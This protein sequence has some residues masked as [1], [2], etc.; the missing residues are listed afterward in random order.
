MPMKHDFDYIVIGSGFGGSV[1]ALRLAEKGYRVC[2]IERGKRYRP[3][4]FATSNWQL[5]KWLWMPKLFLRGIQCLTLLKNSLVLTGS[6]VGGGSLGYCAVLLEPPDPFFQDPQWAGLEKDWRTVLAPFYQTARKMLG[7]TQNP[8]LWK[9]DDLIREYARDIGRE[10]S[11]KPTEVGIY[12]GDDQSENPDPFFG[13]RGPSRKGCD[14]SGACMV[15]CRQGGKNSLDKN[16]LYL[17]EKLGATILPETEVVAIEPDPQGGYAVTTRSSTALFNKRKK[18][19][20]SKGVVVSAGALGTNR[21][22]LKCKRDNQLPALS[23]RLGKKVRTNSEV[24]LGITSRDRKADFSKGISITSSLFIDEVTHIEPVRYPAGSD[25]MFWLSALLTDGG[26]RIPRPLRYLLTCIRH[27]LEFLR[28]AIPFGWAKRS[29]IL[30]VMQTL[31]NQMELF[32]KRKWYFPFKATLGSR[33]PTSTVP[34]YIPQ[35]NEAARAIAKKINGV[36]KSAITE[37]LFNAPITAHIIGGCVIGKD[38]ESGVVDKYCRAFSYQNFYIID[39][40]VIPANLGVN[41]SL[42]ITAVAEY[43]M[44]HVPAK[45]ET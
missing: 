9:S 4:D 24:L 37:V 43:A 38:S 42:T 45:K 40:S 12:F 5:W 28:N 31:D 21:L 30:L 1:S 6:G 18:K 19:L 27:P 16:Y 3:R 35:A 2:V 22:L 41:P 44:S 36:P 13:G 34:S 23:A 33:R 11:F 7:V 29:I 20:Y 39:G 15:G 10:D 32:L 8:Q 14:H 25:A 26:G 17:A